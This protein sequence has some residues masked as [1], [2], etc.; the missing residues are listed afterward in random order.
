MDVSEEYGS[1]VR[2]QPNERVVSIPISNAPKNRG[3]IGILTIPT[4]ISTKQIEQPIIR[5]H[6]TLNLAILMHGSGGHKNYTY[7]KLTA[8]QL[9]NDNGWY[10]FRFD[11]RG[12]GDSF[13]DD[14][15]KGIALDDPE[16]SAR[17][18]DQDRE[19]LDIVAKFW[20]DPMNYQHLLGPRESKYQEGSS[21]KKL[22]IN[23]IIAHSR[24]VIPMF[25]WSL[26]QWQAHCVGAPCIL[27]R[28]LINCSGRFAGHKLFEWA[29]RAIDDW[30]KV[31]GIRYS[32]YKNKQFGQLGLIPREELELTGNHEYSGEWDLEPLNESGYYS[33]LTIFGVEEDKVEI[34]DAYRFTNALH[35]INKLILIR[36]ADH[37]YYGK[38]PVT[39]EI[40]H[41]SNPDGWPVNSRGLVNYNHAVAK[42]IAEFLG[43]KERCKRLHKSVNSGS[44]VQV[45]RWKNIEGINNFRDIGGYRVVDT[46]YLTSND[47][48]YFKIGKV[49]RCADTSKITKQGIESLDKGLKIGKV[50]DLRSDSEISAN[51]FPIGAC[52]QITNGTVKY[53]HTPMF[54]GTDLSPEAIF[55]RYE[56]LLASPFAIPAVYMDFLD[57]GAHCIRE[58]FAH[59]LENRGN[60][61][62]H[63]AAGKDR[64][65][66][67]SLLMLLVAGVSD[68][69]IACDYELTSIGLLP[70]L[71][72][73]K[74]HFELQM[75]KFMTK[76][77]AYKGYEYASEQELT[78]KVS[79]YLGR[80]DPKFDISTHG[81]NNLVSSRYDTM[82]MTLCQFHDKY[83][84]VYQYFSTVLGF[85]D[86]DI[87]NIKRN[88]VYS[89]SPFTKL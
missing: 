15:D 56:N 67:V 23:S 85:D 60:F 30:P 28:N 87:A 18:F 88:L 59:V 27:V 52:E 1:V 81:F 48:Y 14:E 72:E 11:F 69:D 25:Q 53:H 5:A 7:L 3:L 68:E 44:M 40:E 77:A 51:P 74:K 37:N 89:G 34:E 66:V 12:C 71:P 84:D 82:L 62:Y 13:D 33:T 61:V 21:T 58:I 17:E 86:T 31:D 36:G 78:A 54:R 70:Q 42:H 10:S 80:G 26:V 45:S 43:D 75:K 76:F 16:R 41:P 47:V 4:E 38:F 24:G 19:D 22:Y 57:S 32:M 46:R 6:E 64:T 29:G 79:E 65:G 55:F 20:N 8:Q 63:C 73:I 50:F 83:G 49:F 9:A 35:K 2:I 39:P